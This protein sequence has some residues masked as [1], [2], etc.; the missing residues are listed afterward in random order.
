MGKNTINKKN[1]KYAN[2]FQLSATLTFI[3]SV[4]PKIHKWK[5]ESEKSS[6]NFICFAT[7][8]FL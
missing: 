3:I 7:G 8:L 4:L 2:L 5:T 6:P 1:K